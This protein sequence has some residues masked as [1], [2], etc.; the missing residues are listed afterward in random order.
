[1]F[2]SYKRSLKALLAFYN[3]VAI[4]TFSEKSLSPIY[5]PIDKTK[6]VTSQLLMKIEQ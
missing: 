5:A 3:L 4:A 1:M 6:L 2:G